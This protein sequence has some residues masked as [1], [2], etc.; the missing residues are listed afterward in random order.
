VVQVQA[1]ST[2]TETLGLTVPAEANGR[3]QTGALPANGSLRSASVIDLRRDGAQK[4]GLSANASV[5]PAASVLTLKFLDDHALASDVSENASGNADGAVMGAVFAVF[6]DAATAA[7]I[8]YVKILTDQILAVDGFDGDMQ[9][10]AERLV[11]VALSVREQCASIFLASGRGPEFSLGMDSGSVY[12]AAL[13]DASSPYNVWGDAMRIANI[14]AD[15]AE[16]GTIQ[17]S[18]A[19]YELLRGSCVF[20]RRGAF[21]LDRLGEMTTFT[22]RGQL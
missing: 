10:A 1:E 9:G 6:E 2:E 5:F 19:T 22:L 18:E 13:G 12:G 11:G 17:A 8:P 14:L 20:R 3:R 4:D 21:Y 16:P 7:N 15:T